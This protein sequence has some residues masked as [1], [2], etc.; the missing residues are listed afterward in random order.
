MRDFK[1]KAIAWTLLRDRGWNLNEF[2]SECLRPVAAAFLANLTRTARFALMPAQLAVLARNN[3]LWLDYIDATFGRSISPEAKYS[4]R[5]FS[6]EE[7]QLIRPV[8]EKCL[9]ASGVKELSDDVGI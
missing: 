7:I 5:S 2:A 9:T 8:L 6:E 1:Y 4:P 3:Q